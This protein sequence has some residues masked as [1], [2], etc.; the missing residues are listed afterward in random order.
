MRVI[1]KEK[2]RR[3]RRFHLF[4]NAFQYSTDAIILTDLQGTII[5]ANPAFTNLFGWTREEA[6]GQNTRILRSRHTSDDFYRQMWESIN[7]RGKW[8]GEIINRHKDGHEIP[9]LLSITPIFQGEEKIGYMGVEIDLTEKKRMETAL[10]RERE[11]S[12]SLI[13]T[14]NCL[15]VCL[16]L[17]GE[18]TLFN[19]KAE[20]VTGYSR[21]E[22]LGRNWFEIFLLEHLRPEVNEVFQAVVRGELP[23]QYENHIMTRRGDE[24]LISWANT[25]IRDEHQA[26]TGVLAIGIDITDQKRLEKQ[27]LQ[28]ERLATIGKMA[29]KVAHEI[30]NPLSSISLNAE[31]L[32]DEISAYEA[33]NVEEARALLRAIIAEIDRMTALTEEYLQFSRLPESRLVRGNLVRLIEETVEFLRHELRQKR[34]EVEWHL[35]EEVGEVQFDR[36]Q[37]RRALLNLIRNAAEAMPRGGRLRIRVEQRGESVIIHI[38]DTGVGI[39]PE[40]IGKIFEPFF[41]TKEVGTGLGLAIV[42]QIITEHGGRIFCTSKVGQG[43]AFSI[44]LPVHETE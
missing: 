39:P 37:M 28:A 19:R 25:V 18:I 13:E 12:A 40:V 27:V 36:V 3:E 35:P 5:E 4:L 23:S 21:Y 2:S 24:R 26:V 33:V 41:T 10:Q 29:A 7:S 11:F 20:E 8:V 16:N 32:Q 43:T 34:V 44:I 1:A 14:A 38:E 6:V 31:M 15:I 30:R 22:V 9:I 42:Q 17:A